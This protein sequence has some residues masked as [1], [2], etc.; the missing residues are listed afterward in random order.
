MSDKFDIEEDPENIVTVL[1]EFF[2]SR[3]ENVHT[4]LPGQIEGFDAST[5]K[6][7]V[8]P[9]VKLRTRDGYDIDIKPI[10]NVPVI[11]PCGSAF[12]LKFPLKKNDKCLIVSSFSDV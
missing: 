6:A 1:Q 5:R 10:Q 4:C 3:M 2:D 11:F 9:L 12:T 7:T 8:K